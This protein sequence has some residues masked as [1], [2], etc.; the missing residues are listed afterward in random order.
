MKIHTIY[1]RVKG[2]DEPF[3]LECW[4]EDRVEDDPEGFEDSLKRFQNS[5]DLGAVRVIVINVPDD[6]IKASF[7]TPVIEGT[8]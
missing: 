2:E 6:A 5:K 3:L 1:G 7:K 8:V 4:G